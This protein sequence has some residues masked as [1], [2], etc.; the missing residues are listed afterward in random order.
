RTDGVS[1]PCWVCHTAGLGPNTRDD[2]ELQASY[3]FSEAAQVNHWTN[4]FVDRGPF[5]AATPD[6]EILAWV[7]Q[8]DYGPLR[9]ALAAQPGY[10][11]WVPDLDLDRGFDDDGFARDGSGWRAVRYQP[12]PGAFWPGGGSTDDV[13]VRLPDAFQ[14]GA[15]G[16]P[17]RDVYRL[18]LALVEAAIAGVDDPATLALDREVEPIDER[19]L[20]VD[21]D[22]DGEVRAATD[23]IRRLPPRYAGAAAAVKVEA[24]VLPLG[25]ELMHSVRY[26]D[27]DEPGLRARRMKELRYMRKVEAPDAWAR[28]RAY[29]H[30]A[31]EKDEGRLPRYRGDALE[32]LVNAFGWRLQGFIED[33]D[34]RLRL[35]TDEEHRF[36][37]G[38]H[39]NLGVTV[40]ST[41]ALA[42]KV[43]GR[44]GWRP[45]DLRGLRDRPQVGHVD[46]EVLTYFRRVGG[47]DETRSNDELIA[48]YVRR[49]AT[50]G[51][52]PELDDV[53]LRRAGPGGELDLVGLLA[54]SR[55]RAL[56]LDK[57]YLAVVR[58]QSFVRGRDAVLAPAT[59][60]QRRVDDA[61]TG[62]AAAGRVYRDG[63]SHLRWDPAVSR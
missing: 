57:A 56:A 12:F 50:A 32:G 45:Q 14:R 19:L 15:D 28:L 59:R 35:Q 44:D 33:A 11:G 18:N 27:P 36:C 54:P 43:P 17:S 21:L 7:R 38:C 13:F 23:R 60:V 30:E 31:D 47:G 25:T 42:R 4:L 37:M 52:P 51:T 55:A 20:G 9:A 5:I 40:D 10:R 34:G 46:G 61:S 41:F 26:L 1:N 29:E 3:G 16:V 63:R 2:V 49:A 22:G 53:A 24:L 58:E 6:A 48:R 8:D 62:L 39:Q